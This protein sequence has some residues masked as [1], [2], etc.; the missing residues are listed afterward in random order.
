VL[1]P[2]L[3]PESVVVVLFVLLEPPPQALNR[4]ATTP[5]KARWDRVFFDML[6]L[7]KKLCRCV[8]FLKR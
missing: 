1:V 3:V 8:E 5:V 6:R 2:V 7:I 4:M